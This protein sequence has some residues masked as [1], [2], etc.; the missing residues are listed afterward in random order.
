MALRGDASQL[1]RAL[2]NLICNALDAAGGRV[3]APVRTAAGPRFLA[4]DG[5]APPVAA[6]T[7][8]PIMHGPFGED[9]F[10]VLTG[11]DFKAANGIYGFKADVPVDGGTFV[12]FKQQAFQ[13][14][15]TPVE[16]TAV[17]S[18]HL[19]PNPGFLESIPFPDDFLDCLFTSNAVGWHIRAELREADARIMK[20]I[21][22]DDFS[23][24]ELARV[25]APAKS[26]P[27]VAV[28]KKQARKKPSKDRP[29]EKDLAVSG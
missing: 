17:T 12:Y 11:S 22:V 10:P 19:I 24:E 18:R 7:V 9:G 16:Q 23:S 14:D 3:V 29:E 26:E 6:D 5:E 8:F 25:V 4:L 13:R 15:L 21:A 28:T 2:L 1:Q 27:R 20:V